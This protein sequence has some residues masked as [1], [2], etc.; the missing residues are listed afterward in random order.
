MFRLGSKFALTLPCRFAMILCVHGLPMPWEVLTYLVVF[1]PGGKVCLCAYGQTGSGKSYSLTGSSSEQGPQKGIFQ[2]SLDA[3]FNG[4]QNDVSG[5]SVWIV[6][7][8][9]SCW[10]DLTTQEFILA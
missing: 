7:L 3:I 5:R 2:S 10:K 4:M 6:T 8:T 9:T 1:D